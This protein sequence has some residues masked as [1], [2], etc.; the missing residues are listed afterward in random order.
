MAKATIKT[1]SVL[2]FE[3]KLANSDAMMFAGNWQQESEWQPVT[4]QE[5]SVRGT[6]SNRLKNA[7]ASD[8]AKLDTEIQKANLQRVDAAALAF[9]TD[10][11]KV[12]F[13]LRVMGN[14]AT[15][16]VCNDQEYQAALAEVIN[17]YLAE[18]GVGELAARYAENLANGRFLWRNRVGAD[19]IK[20]RVTGKSKTWEFD[21]EA[22]SLR[23]FGQPV[24]ALAELA[25]EI[26]Q[27]LS[28]DSF[29][30]FNVEALVRL[31]NGQE[32]FPSQELVLD[33]NSK[34]S[35]VLYQVNGIAALHSQKIGNALRTIDTWYPEA[36]ELGLGPIA[37]EPYGSVTSRGRAYRQP[38]QKMDFY[39]LL[40][41]WVTKGQV[42]DVEQQHYVMAILIR[43]GVFG[44]KGE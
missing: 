17:G 39:T 36:D 38:K 15:P 9:D 43:G 44:E 35:K 27:G 10:T 11:L 40:D 21:G 30:L 20:V 22:Y 23:A 16:S 13:T 8:P 18:H 37:V 4:I 19:A 29:A 5:K 2:A 14:L 1:A 31:G 33:S 7:I 32:V 25:Q 34:K 41:N 6:I 24:G 3:R 42:P 12:T 26:Q 28:G